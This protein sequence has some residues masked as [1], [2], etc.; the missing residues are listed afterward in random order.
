MKNHVNCHLSGHNF[1]IFCQ[2][3]HGSVSASLFS[4]LI[5]EGPLPIDY[6]TSIKQKGKSIA[7]VWKYG[8]GELNL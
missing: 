2:H 8:W 1:N 5:G 6:N 7:I 4:F 3:E